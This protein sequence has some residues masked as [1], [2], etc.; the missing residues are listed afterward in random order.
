M[1]ASFPLSVVKSL[2]IVLVSALIVPFLH[3]QVTE[4]Y[5]GVNAGRFGNFQREEGHYSKDFGKPVAGYVI[6][7]AV[8]DWQIVDAF[9]LHFALQFEQYGGNFQVG[10]GGIG[11]HTNDSGS[12]SKQVL[13][14]VF[15]PFNLTVAHHLHLSAG[16]QYSSL[17]SYNLQGR[18]YQWGGSGMTYESKTTP[19]QN[20]PNFIHNA[21]FGLVLKAGYSFNIHRLVLHPQFM[22]QIGFSDEFGSSVVSAFHQR[23]SLALGIGYRW[24][25]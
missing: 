9:K 11:S 21:I 23:G 5:G 14:V 12:V 22:W 16:I 3:A 15:Y 20:L 13:G 10:A 24:K 25:E 1:R 8:R 19:L 17:L 6:G 7:A 2:F 18:R 4:F